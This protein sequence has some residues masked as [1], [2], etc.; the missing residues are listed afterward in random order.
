MNVNSLQRREEVMEEEIKVKLYFWIIKKEDQ[1]EDIVTQ[2]KLHEQFDLLQSSFAP[3]KISFEWNP[4][5]RHVVTNDTWADGFDNQS[6]S[7]RMREG[8]SNA[9][10]VWIPSEAI[11]PT[12]PGV[13]GATA[14]TEFL[15]SKGKIL[16]WDKRPETHG[17]FITRD[18]LPNSDGIFPRQ[19]RVLVHEVGHWFGLLHTFEGL[20]CEGPGDF[21]DDT[22]QE[23]KI[24]HSPF[25]TCFEEGKEPN[26][27]PEQHPNIPDPFYNWM[28]YS[29]E[30][31]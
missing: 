10:N 3:A 8:D 16:R 27:C 22:P 29:G 21:I 23:G 2:D 6:L 11:E 31:W 30:G 28:D 17:V 9:L 26:S 25:D 19:G 7:E 1:P 12:M 20:D 24:P 4:D 14:L 5:D 13:L 15:T 18:A